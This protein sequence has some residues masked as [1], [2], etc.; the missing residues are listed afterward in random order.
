MAQIANDTACQMLIMHTV[1][2][3]DRAGLNIALNKTEREREGQLTLQVD[4][5]P[6]PEIQ[7]MFLLT[8]V[9]NSRAHI[10]LVMVSTSTRLDR[11]I[12]IGEKIMPGE[13]ACKFSFFHFFSPTPW[14]VL[15]FTSPQQYSTYFCSFKRNFNVLLC[16]LS[17][18]P[19]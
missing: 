18:F 4:F 15:P 2:S 9:G 5:P 7:T 17:R 13:R 16:F 8:T 10:R 19:L 1:S 12:D 3:G 6:A 14:M 11:K